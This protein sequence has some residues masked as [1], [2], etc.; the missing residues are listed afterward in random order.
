VSQDPNSWYS[1]RG[2]ALAVTRP[3]SSQPILSEGSSKLDYS[4]QFRI[5]N[6]RRDQFLIVDNF[7]KSNDDWTGERSTGISWRHS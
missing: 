7:R 3:L 6:H 4:K 2:D 1:L 5:L